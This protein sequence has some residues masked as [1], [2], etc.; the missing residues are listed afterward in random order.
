MPLPNRALYTRLARIAVVALAL[1]ACAE[2]AHVDTTA[3][4]LKGDEICELDGMTL[5]DFPGP[6]GQIRYVDGKTIY[7][8]DTVEL[9]S[10]VVAPEQVRAI[11]GAYTQDMAKAD[12]EQP[13]GH[14]I[15][16]QDAFY[17]EGSRRV[18]SMGPT[19]ASFANRV[20]AE[21]FAREHGGEVLPFSGITPDKVQLDGG[22]NHDH[23]M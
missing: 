9:L 20:D 12:W 14:W 5:S 21:T 22:M 19:L 4:E 8:C 1:S 3:A 15:R 13:K 18:G 16:V 10:Q 2:P 7:F 6:K 17:V 23:G 11:A